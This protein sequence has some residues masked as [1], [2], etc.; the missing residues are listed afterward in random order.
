LSSAITANLA[1]GLTLPAACEAAK[2]YVIDFL[3]SDP[4]LVGHHS[5]ENAKIY[6]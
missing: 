6:S 1:N 4:G 5:Y 2:Q 3:Q